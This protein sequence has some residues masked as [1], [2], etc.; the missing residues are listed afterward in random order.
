[1]KKRLASAL[2]LAAAFAP[3]ALAQAD[4]RVYQISSMLSGAYGGATPGN[5]LTLKLSPVT[6]EPAHPYDLF[7]SVTGT[8][9]KD[10]IFQ[11]GVI[12]LETQGKDVYFT[13]IPHF[14]PQVSALSN[15]AGR[16]TERELS[17]A[18]SFVMNPRG[19]GF[20]GDT[21]GST[22]CALAI[23]G[24]VGKWSVEIEPGSI[25]L[26]NGDSGETLRFRKAGSKEK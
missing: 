15:D 18:C 12:R 17:S 13:Y 3:L 1:M 22:T 9:E 5:H 6:L 26:R 11:Q 21:L 10:N 8:F 2:V 19:D 7:L 20:A 23:R 24:A 25:R 4:A 14:N 16:F